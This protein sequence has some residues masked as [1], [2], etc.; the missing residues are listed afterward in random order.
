M[1]SSFHTSLVSIDPWVASSLLQKAIRR[2]D[3]GLASAAAQTLHRYRGRGV[4]R[5]LVNIAFED[6]GIADPQLLLELSSAA[7]DERMREAAGEERELLTEFCA[8][9]ASVPKDRSA[10]YLFAI[11]TRWAPFSQDRVAMRSLDLNSKIELL[12]CPEEPLARKAIA[13]LDLLTVNGTGERVLPKTEFQKVASLMA[14]AGFEGALFDATILAARERVHPVILMPI[15]LSAAF[16]AKA[17]RNEIVRNDLPEPRLLG[18]IPLYAYDQ[19][20]SLGKRSINSF[21]RECSDVRKAL[22]N[23]AGEAS[24]LP[25]GQMAVF[26]AEGFQVK[27][28]FKWEG[29]DRLETMG[30]AADLTFLGALPSGVSNIIETVRANLNDLDEIRRRL[31]LSGRRK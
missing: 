13:A 11:A 5:R 7:S 25:V 26:Y 19:Y 6:I 16:A 4:W 18:G 17:H 24:V 15:L 12:V 27:E 8:R 28:Q 23:H 29:A 14:K 31:L 1:S 20:T 30:Q 2:S 10:D 21:V 3:A 9:L 22:R